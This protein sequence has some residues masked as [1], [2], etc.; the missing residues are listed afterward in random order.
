VAQQYDGLVVLAANKKDADHLNWASRAGV[1]IATYNAEPFSLRG[2]VNSL[3]ERVELLLGFNR[4]LAK[5]A[6]PTG[7]KVPNYG[8]DHRPEPD[9]EQL[10]QRQ[11]IQQAV[12][13]MQENLEEAISVADVAQAVYLSPSYFCRVFTEQTGHN[14]SDFLMELRLE[15]A[16]EYLVRTDMSVTDV[17]VALGYNPSYFSRLFKSRVGCTPGQ[18]ASRNVA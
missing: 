16:K 8:F 7:C 14:P 1:T 12:T 17:S 18:Y 2:L 3:T 13:F 5:L 15:R 10:R 11:L 6:S 9:E 4:D